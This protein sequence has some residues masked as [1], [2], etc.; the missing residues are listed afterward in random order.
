MT[1]P[2]TPTV[3]SLW[4]KYIR[5]ISGIALDE[6]KAYLIETRLEP[7]LRDIQASDYDDLY[8]RVRDDRS[9]GLRRKVINAIT[10]NETSFFREGTQFELLRHKLIPELVDQRRRSRVTPIPIRIW[11]AACSTGQEPYSVAIMLKELLGSLQA[12][13]IRILGTDISDQSIAKASYAYFSQLE[14]DRG[15]PVNLVGIYFERKDDKWKVRDEIRSLVTFRCMNLLEPISM[16]GDFD[17]V[18][19]RNVAIYFVEADRIRLFSNVGRMLAP[20]GSLILGATESIGGIGPQFEAKRY[21]RSV[22]YRLKN[23]QQPAGALSETSPAASRAI[24]AGS[25]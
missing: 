20:D 17:V 22:F 21:L 12:Y 10:T 1:R 4:A 16:P 15:M 19:C 25:R 24:A 7:L 23:D 8:R 11:C 18:L 3:L 13:D 6:S 2:L 9:A 14:I 5:N